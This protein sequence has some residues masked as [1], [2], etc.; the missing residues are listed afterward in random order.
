MRVIVTLR[1][2]SLNGSDIEVV[3]RLGVW[4]RE[5]IRENHTAE[6]HASY[7]D[8]LRR[9]P[10]LRDRL[11]RKYGDEFAVLSVFARP[12]VVGLRP[13][14]VGSD[15]LREWL[16]NHD[17]AFRYGRYREAVVLHLVAAGYEEELT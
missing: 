4:N 14:Q 8:L 3:V 11:S 1:Q 15:D 9:E 5:K 16:A 2:E 12:G 13:Q 10:D 7:E 6:I 17:P